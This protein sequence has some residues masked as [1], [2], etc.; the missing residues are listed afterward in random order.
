MAIVGRVDG[1]A[2]AE[3]EH[4]F[5]R[6]APLILREAGEHVA[7]EEGVG[8]LSDFAIGVEEA[9]GCVG[10]CGFRSLELPLRVSVKTNRPF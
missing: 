8:A 9:E 5:R 4:E 2:D 6:C 7:A 1:V 10:D 3:L